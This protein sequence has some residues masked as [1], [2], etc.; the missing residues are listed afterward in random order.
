MKLKPGQPS[1]WCRVALAAISLLLLASSGGAAYKLVWADEFDGSGPIDESKWGYQIGTGGQNGWGNHEGEYYTSSTKNVLRD[2]GELVIRALPE[3]VDG[4]QYT[5]ARI[6]TQ[7]K[8]DWKYCKVEFRAKLPH[9]KGLWPAVWM[10]P[11][12]SVYGGWPRSGEQDILE[13]RGQEPN[14]LLGT[15]HF[16]DE[17]GNHK[18][19]GETLNGE[20]DLSANYHVYSYEW[21]PTT[22]TWYLD[23]KPYSV[24]HMS[25]K[26]FDQ[27]FHLICNV[28]VG[29]DFLGYPDATTTF[30]QEM[31][32]DY[33]RVYQDE[34]IQSNTAATSSAA[35]SVNK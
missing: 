10:M 18:Q 2:N 8:G 20:A 23:S 9:G 15:L 16:G 27:K 30:P 25:G 6:R 13:I 3:Q 5:S 22:F 28:A 31:R 34:N 11:T 33:I 32:I 7:G 24:Q 1:A 14:K 19:L 29:G 12:E 4:K 35:A 17:N 26:P 21:T